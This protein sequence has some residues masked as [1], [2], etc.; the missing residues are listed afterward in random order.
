MVI[1]S[2][3]GTE[4]LSSPFYIANQEFCKEFENYI[5]SKNGLIK[6]SYNAWSYSI[7]GKIPHEKEWV[8]KFKKATYSNGNLI[9]SSEYQN[10][11]T[12]CIWSAKNFTTETS[13]FK[14]RKKRFTDLFSS[15]WKTMK[16][17]SSYSIRANEPKSK[18]LSNIVSILDNLFIQEFVFE[19]EYL[20]NDL[21][22]DL[23][24]DQLHIGLIDKLLEIK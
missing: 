17:H 6:S 5:A 9:L 19:I 20:N 24:T 1:K 10:L 16:N 18:F 8:L 21:I 4:E 3:A 23:R 12:A 15:K 13:N 14:I 11:L 22:I 7:I 2:D